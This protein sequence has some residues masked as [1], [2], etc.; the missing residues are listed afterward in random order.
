MDF[1][2]DYVS[3]DAS[4]AC[5]YRSLGVKG[6]EGKVLLGDASAVLGVSTSIDRNLNGCGFCY[7]VDSPATD[8]SYT[9]NPATPNWDYRVVYEVWID[10]ASF[11]TSG[12]GQAYIESVHASPSK[13]SNNTVEVEPV[14]CPP[15]WDTPYCPPDVIQEGRNCFDQDDECPPNY[16]LYVATEGRSSCQP[17]PFSNYP[18]R[19]PCPEG[20]ELDAASEGRYCLPAG[21]DRQGH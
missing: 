8:A 5:G 6:G 4:S 18:G 20:Y 17:I 10:L 15:E 2:I 12:F 7:T 11:G 3:E 21:A 19:K 14:P 16:A 9:A 1:K 13:L